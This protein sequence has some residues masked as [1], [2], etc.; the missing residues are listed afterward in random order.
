MIQKLATAALYVEDQDKAVR[1]W[2]QRVGFEVRTRRSLGK[3]GSWVE[4]APPGA[5]SCLVL[6]PKQLMADWDE[7]KPSM[8]FECKDVHATIAAMKSRGVTISQEPK[9]MHWGPFAAFLDSEGFEHGLR[10]RVEP[11]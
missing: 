8:V 10:S 4:L 9:T 1:F 7:R 2:T 5:E 3:A 11:E 6:Y